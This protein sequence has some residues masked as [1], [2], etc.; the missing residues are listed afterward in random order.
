MKSRWFVLIIAPLFALQL[1]ACSG[2]SDSDSNSGIEAPFDPSYPSIADDYE[3]VKR[4]DTRDTSSVIAINEIQ[5]RTLWPIG[6][7]DYV[8]VVLTA[9]TDYE[10]SASHL[11]VACDTYMT[12]YDTDGTTKLAS[13]DDYLSLDS[14]ISF[15][16]KKDGTYFLKIESFKE[17]YR[18]IDPTATQQANSEDLK[19]D[20]YGVSVYTLSA[21]ALV[22]ND[23]DGYSSYYDCNDNDLTI[24]PWAGEVI[25][26]GISQNCS[27][28]DQMDPSTADMFEPDNDPSTAKPMYMTNIG[29]W[30]IQFQQAA[31]VQ[32]E[33]TIDLPGEKDYFSVILNPKEGAY[34]NMHKGAYPTILQLTLY[35]SDGTTVLDT[36]TNDW[37]SQWVANTSI[38]KKTFYV[39]YAAADGT[40]TA[41]FVPALYS[42]GIDYDG[43]GYYTRDWGSVRD[44]ND[45]KA[46]IHPG[47]PEKAGNGVD[48]NCNGDDNT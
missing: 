43:D 18:I 21:H 37:P 42:A 35:D 5:D 2:D 36:K 6:D 17:A 22:D 45:K 32:N 13:N 1:S 40:S 46:N 3:G 24:Y 8:K 7:S 30:E 31:W 47:A 4:D 19:G 14:R 39:S 11:C 41:R 28:N 44:C 10:F 20:D 38:L 16:P 27:G 34:L 25:G 48:S 33:R 9:G 23:S 29:L 15:T 26:D 12:L